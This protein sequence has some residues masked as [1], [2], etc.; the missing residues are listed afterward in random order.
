M[1][2]YIGTRAEPTI[3]DNL[4]YVCSGLGKIV[5]FEKATGKLL[6]AVNMLDDLK[7]RN[8]VYGY[9]M[10]LLVDQN[11]LYCLPGGRNINI[12]A[13]DRFTGQ[14]KWTTKGLGETPGYANPIL[15]EL[16]E[17]KILVCYSEYSLMGIDAG[18]GELLWSKELSILGEI[19][20]NTPIYEDGYLYSVG[21]PGNG[22]LKHSLSSDG[23]SIEEVW[24]NVSFNT[25][26]GGFVNYDGFL[27]GALNRKRKLA[28][29]DVITGKIKSNNKIRQIALRCF[30]FLIASRLVNEC[31]F[32][33]SH[34]QVSAPVYG[35]D[36]ILI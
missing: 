15:I 34:I 14:T 9:S 12:V 10:Q 18:T 7:G 2:S 4:I 26:F 16:P 6:W 11:V 22:A 24:S 31:E 36:F 23:S 27:Y 28:S 1:K 3:T 17:R 35:T 29:L 25:F 8:T 19:P 5:C 20:C 33:W 13:L 32:G 21:G 30:M